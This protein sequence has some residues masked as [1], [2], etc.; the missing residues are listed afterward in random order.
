MANVIKHKRG[1]GSDPSASNLVIG[2]L[3]IRTDN[4]KLFTKMDSGAIAEIAG[5]G[6]DIAINTLSSSSGT[7]GG[8]ATFNGSAYRFTLSA[9]PSVSAQQLL[10]SINGV[11]QKP[12]A[13]TGQ[14]SEGFSVDGTDIILGDAPETGSDFFILTFKSLGVSEPADNSVTSAKIADGAI[15]NADINASAAIAGTKIDPDFGSQ[16]ITTTGVI[17]MGNGL[18]LTGTNPFIDIIDS[19]NNSDFTIKNDNGTF[20]IEDKTNSNAVRLAIDSSGRLLLGTTTEGS[21]SADDLTIATSGNT[22]MTIR[23]GTS[24]EGNIFFSDGT[25]GNAEYKGY[26]QYKHDVNSLL[27]GSDSSERMRIDSSGRVHI[28]TATNRL[29]EALH[30]LGNG[31]VTSS[32]EDTNMMLFGTFGSSTAL[33]G[34]FNNIPLVFRQNNTERMRIDSSG[35]VGI[36]TTSPSYKLQVSAEIGISGDVRFLTG[37]RNKFIGGGNGGNLELGTYSSSNTSRDIHMVM[38]S[39]GNVGIGTT[40]PNRN[41]VVSDGTNSII[42]VQNSGQSTEGVFNA[43]SGGTINLG[44]T[45]SYSLTLSTNNVERM[46]VDSSGSV[47]IGHTSFS[48]DTGADDLIVGS[49]NSGANRGITILNHTNQDGRLCFGQSGDP[50]AGMIKYSHGSNLMQFFVESTE[51]MR[52]LSGGGLTFNGDTAAANALDDYEEGNLTWVLAKSGTPSLGSTNGSNVKY[53]K[54]GRLVHISGRIRT[55]GC[56]SDDTGFFVFQSGSTLPFTPETSGTSV[57]GHWRSQDKVGSDLTASISWVSGSTTLY[58][59]T[60]DSRGDYSADSNN[61]PVSSQTNLA[62]TFS[63][64]YR[65]NA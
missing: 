25:T 53:V 60:I 8:S 62:I 11:I 40:S 47:R 1:S 28:G 46:R 54:V 55:D 51:R 43:P 32:A 57:V 20:E 2:E 16:G 22:G 39:A 36:G 31:I 5:G 14:P 58:L 21:G 38:N 63:L 23:S 18:T 44:T 42:S 15:V 13:G 4:G 37:S 65:T 48:A 35:N 50:D 30:I 10:V 33:I 27:F 24:N 6:S 12:V 61:V 49:T 52:I 17:S 64:T 45:G 29:G 9:P 34:S 7:G 19:N 59:Y 3:A 56:G 41:L 26:V